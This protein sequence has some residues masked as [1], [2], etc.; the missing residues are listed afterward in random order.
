MIDATKMQK[1]NFTYCRCH[2]AITVVADAAVVAV[3]AD[4][5]I[6]VLLLVLLL[7]PLLSIL[8]MLPMV[9]SNWYCCYCHCCRY[10]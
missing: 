2:V 1:H 8:L 7:V 3:V 4:A 9:C 6:A 5:T 10:Y